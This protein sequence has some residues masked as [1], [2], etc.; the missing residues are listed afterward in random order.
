MIDDERARTAIRYGSLLALIAIV[1]PFVIFAVPQVAGASQSYVVLSSSMS[2]SIHAGDV[3]VVD[4][5]SPEQIEEGDVITFHPP[6]GHEIDAD[7]VT[8][9]V[10]DVAQRDDG[11]Y[12]RT[13]G[14]ANEEPDQELVP[15]E[16]VVGVVQFHIPYIGYV[17]QFAN[18]SLGIL[19]FVVGPAVLLAVNEVWTLWKAAAGNSAD[20]TEN[21]TMDHDGDEPRGE[22]D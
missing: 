20:E 3:V 16:N 14:D 22:D 4:G 13:K 7:L 12:F 17:I 18:S 10:V 11:R 19:L 5:V 21:D 1:V 9:R 2:P 6:S 15:A 8:H